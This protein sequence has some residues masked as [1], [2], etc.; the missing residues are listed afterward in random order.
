MITTIIFGKSGEGVTTYEKNHLFVT[1]VGYV[2]A[3]SFN[4]TVFTMKNFKFGFII[5]FEGF[6]P[7]YTV[8]YS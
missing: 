5:C 3:G 7:K 6:Y 8:D 2:S 4:P 1:E